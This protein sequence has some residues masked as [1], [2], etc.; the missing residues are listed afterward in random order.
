MQF[1]L[2]PQNHLVHKEFIFPIAGSQWLRGV[3]HPQDVGG[4]DVADGAG[5]ASE[6][7]VTW[8]PVW[9]RAVLL[10]SS[11]CGHYF[12]VPHHQAI[13]SHYTDYVK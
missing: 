11:K 2:F 7:S 9:G 8:T 4:T 6:A 10:S 5:V 12:M 1:F 13:S 3:C